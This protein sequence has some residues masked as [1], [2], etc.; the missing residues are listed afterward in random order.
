MDI[1]LENLTKD[2]EKIVKDIF[3]FCNLDWNEK[4]F[5]INKK[6][7]IQIKTT[8]NV[9]LRDKVKNYDYDKYQHYKFIL[10][11]YKKKYKW[12]DVK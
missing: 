8:S 5:N 9:Q 11:K 3:K 1:K 12:L 10:N 6:K 7:K 4:L 2:N